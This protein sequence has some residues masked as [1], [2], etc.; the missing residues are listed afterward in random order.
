MNI[1]PFLLS[2]KRIIANYRPSV[3]LPSA[4]RKRKAGKKRRRWAGSGSPII[5]S[6][7]NLTSIKTKH[8][9]SLQP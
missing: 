3:L 9:A 6:Y 1:G 7:H 8:F 4:Q 5:T 2:D